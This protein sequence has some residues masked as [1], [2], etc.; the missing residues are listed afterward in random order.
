MKSKILFSILIPVYNGDKFLEK[1]IESVLEQNFTNYEIILIDDGSTDESPDICDRY[2]NIDYRVKV[3]HKVNEGVSIARKKGIEKAI[4]E[5][6]VCIDADDWIKEKLLSDVSEIITEHHPDILMYGMICENADGYITNGLPYRK[7]FYSRKDIENEIFP[8]LIQAE[9][10]KY[11]IPSIWGKVFNR[12]LLKDNMFAD[13]RAT[14]GEDSACVIP[15]I[16]GAQSMYVMEECYYNYRY[17][18]KSLTKGKKVFHWEYPRVVNEHIISKIDINKADFREQMYRKIAHDFFNAAFSQFYSEKSYWTIKKDI[19]SHICEEPYKTAIEKV[20]FKN[21]KKA[22]I[23]V[24][25]LKKKLVFLIYLYSK[26]RK[27]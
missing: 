1:C 11:F 9:N 22:W 13:K 16:V 23:M 12:N 27:Y 4:G 26:F 25:A 6:I 10:A 21:S 5:Y 3:I 20:W 17:N 2:S 14:V 18:D 19:L 15:S 24:L 7:G 8:F